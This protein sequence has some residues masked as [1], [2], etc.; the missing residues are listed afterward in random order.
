MNQIN[1]TIYWNPKDKKSAQEDMEK[2]AE[3]ISYLSTTEQL[4]NDIGLIRAECNGLEIVEEF[5]NN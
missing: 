5:G 4:S 2:I 1:I 3:E